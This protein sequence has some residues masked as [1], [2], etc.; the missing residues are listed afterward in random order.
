[1][2]RL[3]VDMGFEGVL[4]DGALGDR[5]LELP[6][7]L[8]GLIRGGGACGPRL[9]PLALRPLDRFKDDADRVR[10]EGVLEPTSFGS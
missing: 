8:D 6:V 2:A 4:M 3:P 1:M 5:S 10:F 9:L 7:E